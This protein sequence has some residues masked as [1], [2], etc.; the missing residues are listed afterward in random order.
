MRTH[1]YLFRR[2]YTEYLIWDGLCW[3]N[4]KCIKPIGDKLYESFGRIFHVFNWIYGRIAAK[5]SDILLKS[6]LSEI[7][8]VA[9]AGI[10]RN[11]YLNFMQNRGYAKNTISHVN[12]KG[13]CKETKHW[14]MKRRWKKFMSLWHCPWEE[15]QRAKTPLNNTKVS[16]YRSSG[17]GWPY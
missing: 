17:F 1:R 9:D 2:K 5:A 8:E 7:R 12:E 15:S 11:P 14:M 13:K 10:E 4:P 3:Q 6:L 16:T